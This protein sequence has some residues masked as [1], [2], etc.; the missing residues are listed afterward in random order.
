MLSWFK[1]DEFCVSM[2]YNYAGKK[3]L[4]FAVQSRLVFSGRHKLKV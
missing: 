1:Y 3:L 4:A 2:D